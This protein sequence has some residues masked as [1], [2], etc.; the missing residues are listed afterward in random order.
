MPSFI[1]DAYLKDALYFKKDNLPEILNAIYPCLYGFDSKLKSTMLLHLQTRNDILKKDYNRFADY[2]ISATRKK[3]LELFTSVNEMVCAI[4]MDGSDLVD[5]PRQ[6]LVILSQIFEHIILI[7][8]R[9]ENCPTEI[10]KEIDEV[11]LSI[12]GMELN[13]NE[14]YTPLRK[15]IDRNKRNGFSVLKNS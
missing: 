12:E 6:P 7:I 14:I 8:E 2:E 3:A 11:A 5:Y 10:E 9:M 1:E 15:T 4:D 13:F